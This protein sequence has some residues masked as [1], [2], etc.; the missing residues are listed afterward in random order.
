MLKQYLRKQ[1]GEKVGLMVAYPDENGKIRIGFSKCWEKY[2]I[3]DKGLANHIAAGRAKKHSDYLPD[4]YNIPYTMA[5]PL[6]YFVN[7][8]K[9]YYKDKVLPQWCYVGAYRK[10]I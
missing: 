1:N 4:K 9:R 2:D 5:L 6:F 3:F 7:R 10:V 8:A